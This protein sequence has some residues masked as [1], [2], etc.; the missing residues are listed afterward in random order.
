[1]TRSSDDPIQSGTLCGD[2]ILS[3]YGL[4][5]CDGYVS[6]D[7]D[8]QN[9]RGRQKQRSNGDVN[10]GRNYHGLFGLGGVSSPHDA[11]DEGEKAEAE[12][13]NHQAEHV[14]DRTALRLHLQ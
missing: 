10:D 7:L 9:D 14:Y 13:R 6:P 4:F 1:M 5:E 2:W 3:G 12:L 8:R 11:G